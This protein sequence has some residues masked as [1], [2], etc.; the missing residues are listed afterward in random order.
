MHQINALIER[1]SPCMRWMTVKASTMGQDHG[2]LPECLHREFRRA[3]SGHSHHQE[4]STNV[5]IV[6][7]N[8]YAGSPHHGM[9]FRP[10][11]MARHWVLQGHDV[12]IIAG[13]FSHLRN[14]NPNPARR[15]QEE[16]IDGIRYRW[17]PTPAY[18][19]NG[20]ARLRNVS[21]FLRG[22]R[23]ERKGFLRAA[24]SSTF[25]QDVPTLALSLCRPAAFR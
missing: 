5:Q 17:L 10:H 1:H 4:I 11:Q 9:E 2:T 14:H 16:F 20:L 3:D 24:C 25:Q 6:L 7:I 23:M 12:T 18:R 15:A 21:A 22:L 13:S 8:Q 19:G